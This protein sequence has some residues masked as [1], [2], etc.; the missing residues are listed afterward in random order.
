[1]LKSIQAT[2]FQNHRS[3]TLE[4]VEG[5]NIVSG[6]SDGGKTAIASRVPNLIINN[7]PSSYPYKP[8]SM[9]KKDQ[10][11][12]KFV[13]DDGTVTRIKSD[14]IDKYILEIE[15]QES[16]EFSSLNRQVPDEV[17]AFLNLADYSYQAQEDRHF[18]ISESPSSRAQM[19]NEIS[20]LSII[21]SSLANINS[22][23]RENT[24]KQKQLDGDIETLSSKIKKIEFIDEAD[25]LL[26]RLESLFTENEHLTSLNT[27]LNSYVHENEQLDNKIEELTPILNCKDKA[28]S[29]REAIKEYQ[30]MADTL[31]ALQEY[32][33]ELNRLDSIIVPCLKIVSGKEKVVGLKK[34]IKEYAELKNSYD[35]LSIYVDSL[36]NVNEVIESTENWLQVKPKCDKLTEKISQYG[37]TECDIS[38]LEDWIENVRMNDNEIINLTSVVKQCKQKKQDYMVKGGKCILC[39]GDVK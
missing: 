39:G 4:L 31:N 8:W 6:D 16:Q 13:F 21:D 27:A 2:N 35:S 33:N 5:V 17:K 15:G 30:D 12:A 24:A 11:I 38:D 28:H 36:T 29:L 1:M 22:K 37:Y 14:T 19:L 18:F 26:V 25:K 7:R 20:G 3:S 9:K 23:I 10:T 34:K 32:V